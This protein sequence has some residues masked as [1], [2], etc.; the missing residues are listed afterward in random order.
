MHKNA[1]HKADFFMVKVI[2]EI[3][4]TGI[5]RPL[6]IK[7]IKLSVVWGKTIHYIPKREY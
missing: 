6:I 5:R 3:Y 1:K 4:G 2:G 7:T